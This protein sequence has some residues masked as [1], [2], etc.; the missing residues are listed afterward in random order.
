MVSAL[1]YGIALALL[2]MAA[3]TS[4]AE[5][6]YSHVPIG[7]DTVRFDGSVG[8]QRVAWAYFDERWLTAYLDVIY[9]AADSARQYDDLADALNRSRVGDHVVT[10]DNGIKGTVEGS[11]PYRRKGHDDVLVRVRVD[12]GRMR[13]KEVWTTAAELVDAGGRTFLRQ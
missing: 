10:I 5:S 6:P 11:A 4:A 7:G 1:R 2:L 13:G 8:G 12:D 9:D 3:P